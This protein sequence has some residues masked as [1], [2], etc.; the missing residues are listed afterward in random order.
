MKRRVTRQLF[1]HWSALRG[2]RPAPRREDIDPGRI[3]TC[4][5]ETFV[6]GFDT[7]HGHPFR[8]A[9]TAICA[10]FGR[11]LTGTGFD[12][13]WCAHERHGM[14]ALVRTVVGEVNGIVAGVTGRNS[15]GESIDLELILLPLTCTDSG[16]GR[17]L[18]ALTAVAA[19]YWL[20]VRPLQ[21][22][23]M[24]ELRYL[25]AE[26]EPSVPAQPEALRSDTLRGPGFVIY[27]AARRP[28]SRNY[29][30]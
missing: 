30:G 3:S 26:D 7:E 22:L 21:T 27:P 8:I 29:Q 11:E 20:S 5:A 9:G 18:G 13:L 12:R 4:L 17:V 14:T 6:L 24:G 1:E 19:P 10:M 2:D 16:A 25:G 15:D 23:Q 28:I